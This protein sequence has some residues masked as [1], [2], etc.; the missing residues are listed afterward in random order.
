MKRILTIQDISGV[1]KCSLTV[2]L[3]IISAAQVEACALPTAVLS[4]H[5]RFKHYTFVDLTDQIEPIAKVWEQEGIDFDA[6]YTGYLGSYRQ[7]ELIED[8][9]ARFRTKETFVFVD[10]VLGDGGT[11]YARFDQAFADRMALFCA[12]ADFVTPNLTEAAAM[13]RIPYVEKGYEEKDVRAI[14]RRLAKLGAG[15]VVLKGVDYGR[16]NLGIAGYD[17]RSDEFF[18]YFHEK[19]PDRYHGVGDIFASAAVAALAR[20]RSAREAFQI[21]ADLAVDSIRQTNANPSS[22]DYGVDFESAL[23]RFAQ[24]FV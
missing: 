4:T 3:P 24:K 5:T 10:P 2:A 7:M 23:P 15:V 8:L 20:N 18:S 21:A 16:G 13:L 6:I 17:S 19:F 12:K 1:G 11:L 9:I 14:L 22:R